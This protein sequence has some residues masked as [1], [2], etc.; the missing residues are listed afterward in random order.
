MGKLHEIL[1]IEGDLGKTS[2]KLLNETKK[3]F[4]KDNLFN[5]SVKKL[6]MFAEED[7]MLNTTEVV[8]LDTTVEEVLSY[9]NKEVG[10]FWDAVL[11]KD[12]T[13]QIAVADVVLESGTVIAKN[14]PVTFLL[15]LET[16]L[17]EYRKILDAIPTLPPGIRW[18]EDKSEGNGIFKSED[19]VVQ[20]R[21]KK[22]TEFKVAY[23]ATKEH[24]AQI[25]P[26]T[27]DKNVGKYTTEKTCSMMTP[28]E[29]ATIISKHEEILRAVKKARQ[30]ANNVEIVKDSIS[31]S[32]FRY[33]MT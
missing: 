7:Q 15:G 8:K 28:Y 19:D 27:V 29:K 23:E 13:N 14:V 5:G 25:S 12:K 21:T 3:T 6:E 1:A 11:K 2:T 10:K 17:N 22:E 4:G 9:T 16:K 32:I 24:P 20:F 33:I 30:R 31:S 18:K 26:I